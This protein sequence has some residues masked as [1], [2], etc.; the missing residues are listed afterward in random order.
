M[1]NNQ[2]KEGEH[3]FVAFANFPDIS[4][5]IVADFK[6]QSTEKQLT[7]VLSLTVNSS[8]PV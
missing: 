3:R 4:T 6:L 1:L 5:Y 2:V 7:K 8:K